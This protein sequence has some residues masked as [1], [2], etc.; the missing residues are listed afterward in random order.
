MEPS[1]ACIAVDP[2]IGFVDVPV[3]AVAVREGGRV[4]FAVE[5]DSRSDGFYFSYR[6]VSG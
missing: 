4:G 2:V 5:R 1:C 3:A 6:Q